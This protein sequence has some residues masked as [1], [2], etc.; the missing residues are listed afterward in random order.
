MTR[1][2]RK[3]TSVSNKRPHQAVKWSCFSVIQNLCL[4]CGEYLYWYAVS[5]DQAAQKKRNPQPQHIKIRCTYMHGSRVQ[6]LKSYMHKFFTLYYHVLVLTSFVH[7]RCD[8]FNSHLLQIS[9]YDTAIV[10]LK[11]RCRSF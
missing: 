1:L 7:G 10:K 8:I 6:F 9:T 3:K 5:H 11:P 4:V 2:A